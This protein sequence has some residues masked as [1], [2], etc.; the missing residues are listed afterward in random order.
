MSE[1]FMQ[2][3]FLVDSNSWIETLPIFQKKIIFQLLEKGHGFDVILND[4]LT[5][6]SSNT[7]PFSGS[8]P[9]IPAG[10]LDNFMR[11]VKAFICGDAKYEKEREKLKEYG[12]G[13]QL[14]FVSIMATAIAP[15]LGGLSAAAIS[16]II[17]LALASL[18]KVSLNAWCTV[19]PS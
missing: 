4:W 16:P 11:E 9:K 8:D 2:N 3:Y 15:H 12:A 7:A 1:N 14:T 19:Q 18:G 10:F 13:A 5:T 6:A 17:A